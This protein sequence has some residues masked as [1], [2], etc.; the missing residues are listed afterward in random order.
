MKYWFFFFWNWFHEK[1]LSLNL[2][3][4]I[5]V[6]G[7]MLAPNLNLLNFL[8]SNCELG[9][10]NCR[11]ITN[12]VAA[13]NTTEFNLKPLMVYQVSSIWNLE[14]ENQTYKYIVLICWISVFPRTK[15]FLWCNSYIIYVLIGVFISMART[16]LFLDKNI[17]TSNIYKWLHHYHIS[18]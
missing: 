1:N 5:P 9:G 4:C 7:S 16:W 12:T 11:M 2:I 13:K 17:N 10:T 15:F 8:K 6:V 14:L 3:H 18:N